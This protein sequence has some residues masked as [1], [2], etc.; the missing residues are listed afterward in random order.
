MGTLTLSDG[1]FG[2]TL[3][4]VR[5]IKELPHNIISVSQ[6]SKH[7]DFY[8]RFDDK[9]AY[10][11]QKNGKIEIIAGMLNADNVYMGK[12]DL[13]PTDNYTGTQL[14]SQVQTIHNID[15]PQFDVNKQSSFWNFHIGSNHMALKTVLNNTPKVGLEGQSPR[16]V[17][18][19]T[20]RQFNYKPFGQDVHVKVENDLQLARYRISP[21]KEYPSTVYGSFIGYGTDHNIYKIL[22]Q[23]PDYHEVNT[24]NARFVNG[25]SYLKTYINACLSENP[26]TI[27]QTEEILDSTDLDHFLNTGTSDVDQD[28]PDI[29]DPQSQIEYLQSKHPDIAKEIQSKLTE[30]QGTAIQPIRGADEALTDTDS[31]SMNYWGNDSAD[32]NSA[33]ENMEEDSDNYSEIDKNISNEQD[34]SGTKTIEDTELP[35]SSTS[36]EPIVGTEVTNITQVSQSVKEHADTTTA[37]GTRAIH[38][39]NPAKDTSELDK[40]AHFPS[41][42]DHFR[43]LNKDM[44]SPYTKHTGISSVDSSPTEP[45]THKVLD[46]EKGTSP[47]HVALTS[48]TATDVQRLDRG[49]EYVRYSTD[50]HTPQDSLSD[51][52]LT[53]KQTHDDS[54]E[55]SDTYASTSPVS[56]KDL[57][58]LKHSPRTKHVDNH[59]KETPSTSS[60]DIN[61]QA[62]ESQAENAN[63]SAA[64]VLPDPYVAEEIPNIPESNNDLVKPQHVDRGEITND[65]REYNTIPNRVISAN[66]PTTKNKP[67]K[68]RKVH[69]DFSKSKREIEEEV[70]ATT[71][72]TGA[73]EEIDPQYVIQLRSGRISRPPKRYLNAIINK[74]DYKNSDWIKSMDNEISKFE[75]NNVYTVVKIPKGRKPIPTRW[76]HTFKQNDLKNAQYKSRCVAQGYRQKD[77]IDFDC[78][79]VSSPVVDLTTIRL[80]A[81]IATELSM[82]M[83]HLDIEAAY[84]NATLAENI[85]VKPPPGYEAKDGHCWK[86]NKALYGLK[87]SGFHWHE[88]I[89][90]TLE[91][92]SFAESTTESVF[93]KR[94]KEG[95]I[96][97]A[98]YVDDLFMVASKES[99]LQEFKLEL[100]QEFDLKYFGEVT[101]FL[102]IEFKRIEGGYSL[103]QTKFLEDLLNKCNIMDD[104]PKRTPMVRKKSYL[105]NTKIVNGMHEEPEAELLNEK[106]KKL[107]QSAVGQLLWASNNTRPDISYAVSVLGSKSHNP[108]VDDYNN[109]YYVLRYLRSNTHMPLEYKKGRI[110]DVNDKFSIRTY[111]DASF[112]PDKDRKSITGIALYV[113]GN[114]VEWS[115]KKQSLIT[116]NTRDCETVSLQAAAKLTEKITTRIKSL[117][118]DV[119]EVMLLQDNQAVI[120]NCY[121]DLSH[122]KRHPDIKIKYIRDGIHHN[123]YHPYIKISRGKT[124]ATPSNSIENWVQ[125]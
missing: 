48:T 51:K 7:T 78:T 99:M 49:D 116:D 93:Y 94:N 23:S 57:D 21:S 8:C 122:T 68:R 43:D 41:P 102:G 35:Q 54:D 44:N 112:A 73:T 9:Y 52:E 67:N 84:L 38:P 46:R 117:T 95:I 40:D 17:F 31:D 65:R 22:I 24:A 79:K 1:D 110:P 114:L 125:S 55:N 64:T 10:I 107:Y 115:A 45:D 63:A 118:F 12:I 15:P 76:V 89:K 28:I 85:Y 70:E 100:R 87:Q 77:S 60:T 37:S 32:Y 109:M 113:N 3:K 69:P 39:P 53:N 19:R 25:H 120:A 50:Q 5:V 20:Q 90:R 81:A 91:S 30:L 36:K 123:R 61:K 34:Y 96:I 58:G 108:N 27:P 26:L 103:Y 33:T 106:T 92:L 4:D 72:A 98:L 74:I 14:L 59:N 66:S 75:K 104:Q 124:L 29:A 71:E 121:N 16:E 47:K 62:E 101:E 97:I 2:I 56:D 86:L 119:G 6:I 11:G 80:L 88:T 83:H 13:K 105:E 42:N 82:E 18:E 111:S